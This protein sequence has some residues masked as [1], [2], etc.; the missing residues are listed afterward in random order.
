MNEAIKMPTPTEVVVIRVP[1]DMKDEK[2]DDYD[3]VSRPMNALKRL[4]RAPVRLIKRF[5][6]A[7]WKRCFGPQPK[8]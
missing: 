1:A 2:P 4:V 7:L 3:R 5:V 8:K 6:L